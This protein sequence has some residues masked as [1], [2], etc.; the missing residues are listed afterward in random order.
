MAR[1]IDKK[2]LF[3]FVQVWHQG[4]G[5]VEEG[6]WLLSFWLVL[7]DLLQPYSLITNAIG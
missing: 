5:N 6:R 4:E 3:P 1:L 2:P 7:G